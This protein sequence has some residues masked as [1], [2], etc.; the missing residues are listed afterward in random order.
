MFGP[1]YAAAFPSCSANR[2]R[3]Q[4][5]F[6]HLANHDVMPWAVSRAALAKLQKYKRRMD[7]TFHWASS[8]GSDFNFD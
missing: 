3:V 6:V 2:G 1:D 8:R 5:V 4:G 7:G